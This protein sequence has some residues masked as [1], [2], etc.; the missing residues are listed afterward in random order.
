[1]SSKFIED[2][3]FMDAVRIVAEQARIPLFLE[4]VGDDRPRQ[5]HPHQAL[6][7][8]HTEAAKFYPCGLMT[9]KMGEEAGPSLPARST[10]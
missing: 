8:I 6:Y 10:T 5:S 1:M 2:V 9:T 4:T 7:D 3:S